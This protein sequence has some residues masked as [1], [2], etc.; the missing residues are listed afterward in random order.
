MT[1][2]EL[3]KILEEARAAGSAASD[4]AYKRNGNTDWDACGFA[5]V[6]I[7]KYQGKK[8]DGRSRMARVLKAAGVNQDYR[9]V[10]QIWNPGGYQGQSISIKEC[11]ANAFA[12]VLQ[13][14][15]FTAY[16]GSR[17]D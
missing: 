5:W 2:D 6:E 7:Y 1:V 10:F 15:G 17:L 4:D 14:H 13:Q 16:A 3:K 8:L 11:G 9:R 12:K